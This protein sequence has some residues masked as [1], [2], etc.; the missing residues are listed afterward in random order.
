M[1]IRRDTAL[2]FLVE[3]QALAI[4]APEETAGDAEFVA[5]DTVAIDDVVVAVGGQL[6]PLALG[7]LHE[8]I[9]ADAIGQGTALLAPRQFAGALRNLAAPYHG[10]LL[11]VYKNNLL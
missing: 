10:A 11:E 6:A 4:G 7:R 5:A 8:H 9:A 1:R 3:S 2:V